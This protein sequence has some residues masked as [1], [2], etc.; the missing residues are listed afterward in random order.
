VLLFH[1]VFPVGSPSVYHAAKLLGVPIIHYVHNFRPFSVGGTLYHK[2]RFFEEALRGNYIRE[3][4]AGAWQGSRLK[5]TVMALVL[6]RLHASGWVDN[7]RAWVCI[8]EFLKDKLRVAGVPEERLHALRHSW[9]PL[10]A[11][12]GTDDEDLGYYLFLARLVEV[13]GVAVLLEAWRD[14]CARLGPAAPELHVGGEGPLEGLVRAG[15]AANPKVKFLGL[16]QGVEKQQAILGCRA[17]VA[18]SV[19]WEPLGLVTYEAYDYGK[20]MLAARSGGLAETVVP[21]VTGLLHDP[22]HVRSLVEDVLALEA[23]TPEARRE[24]GAA[25]RA[26]LLREA[27]PGAWKQTFA[28]ILAGVLG[29]GRGA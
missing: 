10:P 12:P 13:K 16:V 21:G 24:M 28:N 27:S 18:P 14:V 15:A 5:S 8:S 6:R 19:W 7:V 9:D 2:G 22:G 3:A 11:A 23:R 25:G 20:P 29:P 26:W 17:M 1:N 4:A